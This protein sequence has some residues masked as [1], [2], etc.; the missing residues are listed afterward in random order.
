MAN[1]ASL[2]Y[3]SDLRRLGNLTIMSYLRH[4]HTFTLY[5]YDKT[6]KVPEGTILKDANEIL[7][8]D[9]VFGKNGKWQPFS[10]LFRYKML[11]ET[12]YTWVDMDAICLRPDWDFGNYIFGIEDTEKPE[13]LINNAILK[14]PKD[15]DCLKYL[16]ENALNYN[17][18][19]MDWNHLGTPYDLGPKLLTKSLE[20]FNLIHL[21]QKREAFYPVLP[22]YF[23]KY[24]Y[25]PYIEEVKLLSK[26]SYTAH[27]Y[28]SLFNDEKHSHLEIFNE[29]GF[30][31]RLEE[32]MRNL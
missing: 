29:D 5:V 14:L 26:N 9:L 32:E 18:E 17:K 1:V 3:G 23:Y 19:N 16:Y 8:K 21:A 13:T 22:R 2:W 31:Y 11:M 6:I 15:S 24:S 12:D 7:N 10:D 25:G 20:K 28:D 4:G 30:I 27:V